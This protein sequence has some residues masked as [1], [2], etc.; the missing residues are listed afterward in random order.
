MTTPNGLGDRSKVQNA[1][2][3]LIQTMS[4]NTGIYSNTDAESQSYQQ[5]FAQGLDS[6][7]ALP[8]LPTHMRFSAGPVPS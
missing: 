7:S 2:S 5:A 8:G 6:I 3:N 1:L 4:T